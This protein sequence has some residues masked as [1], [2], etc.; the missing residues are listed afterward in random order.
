MKRFSGKKDF[1]L[2]IIT[3]KIGKE[4]CKERGLNGIFRVTTHE[5]KIGDIILLYLRRIILAFSIDLKIEDG[6][7]LFSTSDFLPDVLPAFIWKL[8]RNG[9]K[10]V[11]AKKISWFASVYHIIPPPSKRPGGLSLSNLFSFISQRMSLYLIAKWSDSI[12][13]ETDFVKAELVKRYKI[14]PKRIVVCQ[15]GIDPK[16]IDDFLW[17]NDKTYDACFL[18]RLHRSKG[19]FDL[20]K[21][22]K[23]VCEYKE[24]AKLAIAGGGSIEIVS[25]VKNRIRDLHLENNVFYLG[26]LS[27]ED[28]YKLLKASKLYV[29]PSYEEGIPITFYEAMYCG[30]PVITYYLPTYAEIRDYLQSVPLGDVKGLAGKI[31]RVLSDEELMRELGERGRKEASEHTWDK[32]ADCISSKIKAIST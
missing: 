30:L 7:I 17:N 23:Y 8:S 13:S 14:P 12:Q 10:H 22:W 29:L 3:S 2:T 15:S 9:L 27:D 4:F 11:Q 24:N 28:K 31:F 5:K 18:A 19:I 20:I 6:T 32:V 16:S 21:A 1:E 25:K 26:F